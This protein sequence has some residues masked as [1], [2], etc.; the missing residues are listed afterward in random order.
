MSEVTIAWTEG[1][2]RAFV[3]LNDEN[4]NVATADWEN[5]GSWTE[6]SG[7]CL[8]IWRSAE[9]AKMFRLPGNSVARIKS[10]TLE[11]VHPAD[12]DTLTGREGGGP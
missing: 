12:A 3:L 2:K 10:V 6:G 8:P 1:R 4:T 5:L 9:I 11:I 7:V